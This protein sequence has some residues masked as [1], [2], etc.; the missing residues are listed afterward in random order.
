MVSLNV[1]DARSHLGND[2]ISF[3][4]EYLNTIDVINHEKVV[5]LYFSS[6]GAHILNLLN[7]GC[8]RTDLSTIFCPYYEDMGG[9]SGKENTKCWRASDLLNEKTQQYQV[10]LASR[11]PE[12]LRKFG[13]VPDLRLHIM[14]LA[15]SGYSKDMFMDFFT[16]HRTGFL[17]LTPQRQIIPNIKVLRMTEAGY[18]GTVSEKNEDLPGLAKRYCAGIIAVPEYYSVTVEGKMQ[19]SSQIENMLLEALEKGEITKNMAKSTLHYYTYHTLWAGT[20]P[21]VRFDVSSGIGRRL[22]FFVYNPTPDE[23]ASYLDAQRKGYDSSDRPAMIMDYVQKIR[24]YMAALWWVVTLVT[25]VEFTPEYKEYRDN[26][27]LVKHTD[28]SLLDNLAMGYN[29]VTNFDTDHPVL[30]VQLDERLKMLINAL[31]SGRKDVSVEHQME[32]NVLLNHIENAPHF[33]YDIVYEV[34][35]RTLMTREDAIDKLKSGIAQGV[36]GSFYAFDPAIGL[37]KLIVFNP[38]QISL[39]KAEEDWAAQNGMSYDE[40][41]E[42]GK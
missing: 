38:D 19:Y 16:N 2:V 23:M 28:L 37:K 32:W 15:P 31:S 20:Q 18:T 13:Q 17:N 36:I 35:R 41:F 33:F 40:M 39:K 3:A 30:K 27:P 14:H 8:S 42:S 21:G 12:Y 34:N 11:N 5:P 25:G 29:F 26:V 6:V 22:N 10:H 1:Q 9:K 24:Q 7:Q 4:A